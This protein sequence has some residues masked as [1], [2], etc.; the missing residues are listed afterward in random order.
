MNRKP[1]LQRDDARYDGMF[2]LH[3]G[4][5]GHSIV[6]ECDSRPDQQR[7]A[8]SM[9]A[10]ELPYTGGLR[11]SIT[12]FDNKPP[13]MALDW[14]TK[15][16]STT[17]LRRITSELAKGC[18]TCRGHVARLVRRTVK[19]GNVTVAMQCCGCGKQLGGALGTIEHPARDTYPEWDAQLVAD[20]ADQRAAETAALLKAH[21][22][23]MHPRQEQAPVVVPD[24]AEVSAFLQQQLSRLTTEGRCVWRAE[25][26]IMAWTHIK[27]GKPDYLR[28]D[29]VA[30]LDEG[31]LIGF[32]V[33]RRPDVA[34]DLGRAFFQ[35]SQYAAGQVASQVMEGEAIGW[36]GQ[37]LKA[38]FLVID[39]RGISQPVREHLKAAPRLFGPANVGFASFGLPP[40]G[41]VTQ[42]GGVYR[43]ELRLELSAGRWWSEC[44]GYRADAMARTA[45][46]GSSSFQPGEGA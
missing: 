23:T 22:I 18:W 24:E 19:G 41:N 15:A 13:M 10:D 30:R 5:A 21:G 8:I 43:K 29:Y 44:Y 45:R 3:G 36:Q 9:Q 7:E 25:V 31:P 35:A 46:T 16:V 28:L 27:R 37:P 40:A 33:K 20:H 42:S 26:R 14:P 4:A 32:E 1:L 17:S 34:A 6:V 12:D 2:R 39:Q 11:P 38:V